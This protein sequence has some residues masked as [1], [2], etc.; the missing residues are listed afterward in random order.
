MMRDQFTIEFCNRLD[1]RSIDW[2]LYRDDPEKFCV[3]LAQEY[4][5][6]LQ[7]RVESSN[8]WVQRYI[9]NF[10]LAMRKYILFKQA[11][12]TG[13]SPVQEYITSAYFPI[14][15]MTS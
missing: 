15:E 4:P 7:Q 2:V 8:D 14:Y 6:F 3:R 9:A 5:L 13:N 12:R 11:E 10:L 1:F